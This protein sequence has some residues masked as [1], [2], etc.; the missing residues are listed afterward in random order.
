M[1]APPNTSVPSSLHKVESNSRLT[2]N[3]NAADLLSGPSLIP[4]PMTTGTTNSG[5]QLS[6]KEQENS[7]AD[8]VSGV[9]PPPPMPL[10]SRVAVSSSRPAGQLRSRYV[11][12]PQLSQSSSPSTSLSTAEN[13]TDPA[14]PT[15]RLESTFS[16]MTVLPT[17]SYFDCS[18]STQSQHEKQSSMEVA[19]PK[20]PYE[21]AKAHWFYSTKT[22]VHGVIWW[23]F[24]ILDSQR[25]EAAAT[26]ANLLY[27]GALPSDAP[28]TAVPV[29][30][31]LYDVLL[32]ERV[33]KPV[34]WPADEE[35]A[36]EVRRVM[37]LYRPQNEQ[38]VLPFS[39]ALSKTLEEHYR[40]TLE[41][42]IWGGRFSLPSEDEP[43]ETDTYIFHNEK[44]NARKIADTLWTGN[45][46]EV[47]EEAMLQYRG[48]GSKSPAN[49]AE[50]AY[51]HRGLREDLAAQ[52]PQGD[53]RPVEHVVFVVHG[54]G[55]IYNMRGEGLISCVNDMRRTATTL[56]STHFK[57]VRRKG[58][59]EFLPVR[60]HSAL[61]SESTGINNRLKRVTLRSIPK[62]RSYTNETLT[63]ILFYTSPKYCQHIIDTVAV[64]IKH[65]RQLFLQRNPDFGG[66]FSIAGHSLG[67]VIVFDLL[68]HQ[69][70][71]PSGTP[72][73]KSNGGGGGLEDED[74]W[75]LLDAAAAST[76][77]SVPPFSLSSTELAAQ[78]TSTTDLTEAQVRQVLSI[79][80]ASGG[81][82]VATPVANHSN[83]MGLPVI[84]YPQLGFPLN[85][86]FLLGSPLSIFLVAR[87][88]ERLPLEFRLPTCQAC[89][90]IFHPFDPVAYRLENMIQPD[91]RPCAVLMP[92]HKGR[93][94][95]HLELKDNIAR[96]GADITARVYQSLRSTWRTLQE[97]AAA[98]TA[99]GA[100]KNAPEE[101]EEEEEEESEAIKRVLS[102]LADGIGGDSP[103][104]GGDDS[105]DDGDDVDK[106]TFPSQLNQGRRLDY[107]LQEGPLESLNDYLFALSSHA[108]YWDSQDCLLF[109]LNQIFSN[110]STGTETSTPAATPSMLTP[111]GSTTH[112]FTSAT[113]VN[114]LIQHSA[115][116]PVFSN[117]PTASSA[118][119]PQ[120]IQH[121]CD[122]KLNSYFVHPILFP[123]I[124]PDPPSQTPLFNPSPAPSTA[125]LHSQCMEGGS[126]QAT[127][128]IGD[129]SR[130]TEDSNF[131]EIDLTP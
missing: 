33:Y 103:S 5:D 13:L 11:L 12:P 57:D 22:V 77:V 83:G 42:N 91:Y 32:R 27:V 122:F 26:A 49:F 73:L 71:T 38:R 129:N 53:D 54:I 126:N 112:D 105:D 16:T 9:M 31:G 89:V 69:R 100:T 65:L 124:P 74:D 92:H 97:F 127:S 2:I 67:S 17:P 131:V 76:C 109:M 114:A 116:I 63:D 108:I 94:R 99:S 21:P 1:Y 40:R 50:C 7:L 104:R 59:V 68:S 3:F 117:V 121:L 44:L 84:T 14:K 46:S 52:L 82:S 130:P 128:E 120:V 79:L 20:M 15:S 119:S 64:T 6:R 23:P 25:L 101:Q 118:L 75:S 106:D 72:S 125:S 60:W 34:Y 61:H 10:S 98:H 96:V 115:S 70:R 43:N 37:W 66:D 35:E 58:R 18:S 86:C 93:K 62:M 110:A 45:E 41:T 28:N 111:R 39:E 8:S 90:N 48:G 55:P 80:T 24:D 95:L 30:G 51:L 19:V 47:E 123:P 88:V 56:L 78:L 102:R 107:V 29:R 113:E 85:T 81:G 36:G 87:G 4:P